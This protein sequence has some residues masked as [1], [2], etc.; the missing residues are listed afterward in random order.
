[1]KIKLHQGATL[2]D[3]TMAML[4]A[5]DN[6]DFSCM[7]V[8]IVPDRFSLQCE[9]LILKLL[10]QKALFN[11]RV[12]SLT[13]FSVELLSKLGVNL[14]KGDVLSSGETLLLTAK[15]I[16]N[17][18][19]EFKTFKKSGIDFCYEISKLI[20]Q[21][22]S[23]GVNAQQLNVEAEGMAGNKYHDLALIYQEYEKLLGDKLDANSRLALLTEKLQGSE[24]LKNTKIYFA[25]FDAFTK[26]GYDLIKTFA[27]CGDEV[28]ISFTQA[29]S[30]GNE[31]IYENDIFEKIRTLS[32]E[33]GVNVEVVSN[34]SDFSPQKEAIVKG[35]FSYQKV[36][37]ENKGFYNHYTAISEAEEVESVAKLIRFLAYSGVKYRDIQIAT[38]SLSSVSGQIENIFCEYDIPFHI[39]TSVTA[40]NTILGNLVR[41]YFE[42]VIMGYGQDKIIDLLSNP[43]ANDDL[44]LIE[45]CQHMAVDGKFRFK[46]YIEKSF[47]NS[48]IFDKI[49]KAKFAKDFGEALSEIIENAKENHD[50]M[51][52]KLE[53]Q[54]EIKEKNINIQVYEIIKDT[55]ELINRECEEE[56]SSGEYFK[57]L[58]LLLSFKQVSTVPTYA[59]GV[60]VGDA[61]ESYFAESKYLII[62][63]GENLPIVSTDNGL[64]SDDDLKLNFKNPIEPTIRMLNRRYRFKLFSLL[65]LAK[66]RLIIFTKRINDEGK[67]VEMPSYIKN[68]NDIFS[69]Q[70][71]KAGEVFFSRNSNDLKITLLSSPLLKKGEK[72]DN[73][74]YS[75]FELSPEL[76][77]LTIKDDRMRVTQIE[78]Y[79]CCPFKHFATYG[80]KL[81][82][83]EIQKFDGRDIGNICHKGGELLIEQIIKTGNCDYDR[84]GLDDFIEQNFA[85]ILFLEN[86]TDKLNESVEKKS[87]TKF[88]KN[89][90]LVFFENIVR[91][92][93]TSAFK[94]SKLEYKFEGVEKN[95][96]VKLIGK[97]DRIDEGG[98]YFR[99]VDYKTGKTGNLL[100]ELKFGEKLQLFLYQNFAKEKLNKNIGGVFY[101]DAKFDYLKEEK[102]PAI[103]KGLAPNNESL[104]PLYDPCLENEGVKSEIVGIYKSARDGQYKGS[105]VCKFDMDM[106]GKYAKHI[107]SKAINEIKSGN[108]AP[109]PHEN[110]CKMCKFA[111]FCGYEI[112]KGVRKLAFKEENEN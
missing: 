84:A 70:E 107:T 109:K 22:K 112:R 34:K 15:A 57:L 29:Q 106:L 32:S 28:N 50:K 100:K 104:I 7:H 52:L 59:D 53:A 81:K 10:P 21:F 51:L 11:V 41:Q 36:K 35:L 27:Q 30:I 73:K 85:R 49:E 77:S 40:D 60:F 105:G 38:G 55:I 62:L 58:S 103:L 19:S 12:T 25:Q 97:A 61:S 99:I 26:G 110:S 39:D 90:M 83:F 6:G 14:K 1:M 66:G 20:S 87:L 74:K 80:L 86:L 45:I 43:L 64:L 79:F 33:C 54:G 95:S 42:V 98:D 4:S 88:I 75:K 65:S 63:D 94:P 44:S 76:G 108:I 46:K 82:E 72:I 16:E 56:I 23:S 13:R 78:Q 24:V 67:K 91:E 111:S 18:S 69:Q 2:T 96:G 92:L 9:K 93:K 3:A 89:Q 47:K 102:S 68:L 8:I 5:I 101:F 31:Y 17:V 71:I 48:Y 37:C